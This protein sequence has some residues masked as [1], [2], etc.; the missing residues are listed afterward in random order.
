MNKNL[1]KRKDNLQFSF[2]DFIN[3]LANE[4][5]NLEIENGELNR[6]IDELAEKV[7]SLQAENTSLKNQV[8]DLQ[9][10]S[11]NY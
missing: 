9:N 1:E 11:N 6:Q 2:T 7:E 3:E 4:I 8:Y 5:T 10:P